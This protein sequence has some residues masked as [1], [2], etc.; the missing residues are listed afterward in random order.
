MS[1]TTLSQF[2]QK[3]PT[4]A[5]E[6]FDDLFDRAKEQR[7]TKGAFFEEMTHAFAN[8]KTVEKTVDNPELV[9]K[10]FNLTK[11]LEVVNQQIADIE[12]SHTRLLVDLSALLGSEKTLTAES[13]IAEIQ[14]TQ[15]R[16]MSV[17]T[18]VEVERPLAANE[19]LFDI[20]EPHL[21]LLKATSERLNTT[22][23]DILLDMFIRYTVEQHAQ[24]FYPFVI[25][26]PEFETLTGH[27]H[28]KLKLWLKKKTQK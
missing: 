10:N 27:S 12:T 28:Q 5:K 22:D 19:I 1:N 17:P 23:K 11:D 13:V 25:K 2:A 26:S 20:P 15:Q 16:A 3:V 6:L 9:E 24:W 18:E 7:P 8:P 4:E 21:S 14:M